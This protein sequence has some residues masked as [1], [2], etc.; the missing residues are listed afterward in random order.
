MGKLRRGG[1]TRKIERLRSGGK[2][3][4]TGK[5]RERGGG[6]GEKGREETG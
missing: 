4:R 6:K 1:E 3:K 2:G 5:D